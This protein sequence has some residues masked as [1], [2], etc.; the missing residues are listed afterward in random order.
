MKSNFKKVAIK[1]RKDGF[2]Y[3]EILKQIPVAK[4]TLSLW[5]REVGLAKAQKQRITK[6][7]I[8]SALRGAQKRRQ[9]RIDNTN[10]I[11][12][13]AQ[14]DVKEVSRRELWLMGV[15]LYW[16]EG[17]KE[18]TYRPGTGIEFSNSDSSMVKFFLKWLI[19]I[20]NIDKNRITFGLYIHENN[21]HRLEEVRRYWLKELKFP[22]S[23]LNY[24]YFKKH[25]VKTK[26]KNIGENYYGNIRIRVTASSGL[27][28][29]ISGW[30]RGINKFYF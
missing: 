25:K 18:K 14:K 28:R 24:I 16:A 26:R 9:Q 19:E 12:S 11:Y 15:M 8:A 6:K 7:R 17:S 2:T 3:S 13:E 20:C 22:S 27:N 10:I 21:K 4:S 29:K 1:F 30:I 5:L 23:S